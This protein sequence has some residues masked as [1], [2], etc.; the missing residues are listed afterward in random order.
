MRANFQIFTVK[1]YFAKKTQVWPSYDTRDENLSRNFICAQNTGYPTHSEGVHS[2][3]HQENRLFRDKYCNNY[4]TKNLEY[5]HVV[6]PDCDSRDKNLS[7]DFICVPITCYPTHSE[8]VNS[9]SSQ[10]TRS[11]GDKYHNNVG[12]SKPECD[13]MYTQ[14][15][16]IENERRLNVEPVQSSDQVVK[17]K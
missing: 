7:K 6:W 9:T 12:N 8:G 1:V 16:N 11:F 13:H 17:T 4:E 14:G 5:E 2:A 10:L 15:H 3:L